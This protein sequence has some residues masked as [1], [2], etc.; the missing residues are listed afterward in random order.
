MTM[1][2]RAATLRSRLLARIALL[3][4]PIASKMP[5]F[6]STL[7]IPHPASVIDA[8]AAA[9]PTF[10]LE[11]R[12]LANRLVIIVRL[13]LSWPVRESSSRFMPLAAPSLRPL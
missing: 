11:N 1:P 2:G 12:V 13:T 6:S 8:S 10:A 9:I 5:P 3:E 4:M 7:S